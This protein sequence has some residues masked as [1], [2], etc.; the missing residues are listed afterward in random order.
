MGDDG[1][2]YSDLPLKD[3]YIALAE[4]GLLEDWLE[5]WTIEELLEIWSIEHIE[6]IEHIGDVEDYFSEEAVEIYY[7]SKEDIE[8]F[9]DCIYEVALHEA[10]HGLW[11]AVHTS[12]NTGLMCLPRGN[13]CGQAPGDEWLRR[14]NSRDI[15]MYSLYGNQALRH[16]MSKAQAEAIVRVGP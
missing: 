7:Y 14:L 5:D 1:Y 11:G 15:A 16:G 6:D 4:R 8:G 2:A 13:S 10:L 9:G 12:T 3:W